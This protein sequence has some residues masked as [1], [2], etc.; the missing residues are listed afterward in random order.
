M[1]VTLAIKKKKKNSTI[2][3]SSGYILLKELGYLDKT[4][5]IGVWPYIKKNNQR[6]P[7]F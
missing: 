3:S 5:I 1:V 4:R 2:K 6:G 7:K